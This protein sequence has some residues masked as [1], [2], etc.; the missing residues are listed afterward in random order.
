MTQ[1]ETREVDVAMDANRRLWPKT[2][3]F[4][5]VSGAATFLDDVAVV[6][7]LHLAVVRSAHAHARLLQVDL[8]PALAHDGVIAALEGREAEQMLGPMPYVQD[9]AHIGARAFDVRALAVDEVTWIGEPI[10]VVV[11]RTAKLALAAA[12]KVVVRYEKLAAITT[13]DVFSSDPASVEAEH[14]ERI[15]AQNDFDRGDVAAVFATAPH[16]CEATLT[17]GRSTTAPLEPRGYV[18][19]WNASG[20]ELT[21]HTSHQQP[22]QLRWEL[23]HMF[24]VPESDVRVI[25]PPVGGSFGLKMTGFAEE[26]LVCLMSRLCQ[27]P[28][29]FVESRSECFLGGGREQVHHVG[30]A[31]DEAGRILGLR[32]HI[33]IPVGAASVSP[34]W[35]MAYVTAASF[36]GGYAV[37]NVEIRSRV[38]VTNQPPWHSCRG[39]GKDDATLVME[40]TIDLVARYLHLD[41]TQVRRMNLLPPDAL[42]HRLPSGYLIDSGDFPSI[43]DRALELARYQ[44]DRPPA[45]AEEMVEGVGVA[46]EITPEGGGHPSGPLRDGGLPT[47]PA[48]EAAIVTIDECGNVVVRSG[49]TNPGGGNDTALASLAATELGT[50]RDRVRVIQGDTAIC[51]PGTGHASSRATSIGGAAVVLAAR[52][53]YSRLREAAA[54]RLHAPVAAIR[55]RNGRVEVHGEPAISLRELCRIIGRENPSALTVSRTYVPTTLSGRNDTEEYR[56][57]YPYV[58]SGVYV[59]R[60]LLDRLTGK[61][62]ITQLVA[63]HDCGTVINHTLVEGQMHGAMAM[64]VG[65]AL[66][67][68]S[69]FD[70]RGDLVTDSFKSYL[71]PR[72][73]DLP[74]SLLVEHFETPSPSTLLGSKGA[75]EAGVGGTAAAVANAVL[76]AVARVPG[77]RATCATNFPLTPPRVLDL[78]PTFGASSS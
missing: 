24:G 65:L 17:V 19:S 37:D 51:P 23:S 70:T 7:V 66:F 78:L 53:L 16:R 49:V 4:S 38:V 28:V 50:T 73:N 76:D 72:A 68:E 48:P 58:S 71:M 26:P 75:G 64:G 34:G 47:T 45:G 20:T 57:S 15:L 74:A 10:A 30:V 3:A 36:P 35:R 6:D 21:V 69:L 46:F 67:E 2:D 43:L 32:D 9:P 5:F 56:Y 61:V 52:D 12:A 59:A 33:L 39:Y 8:R 18:A 31:F 44:P 29:K 14:P 41:P 22:F 60:V 27:R 25:V 1:L 42:P 54:Q 77:G 11:A 13:L 62:R 63:V 55:V 40:R